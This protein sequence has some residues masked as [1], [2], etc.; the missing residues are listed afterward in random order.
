MFARVAQGIDTPEQALDAA[1]AQIRR[2]FQKWR[3]QGL[4]G[5][6]R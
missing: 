2:V 6:R 4:V 1:A 3:E 5:G